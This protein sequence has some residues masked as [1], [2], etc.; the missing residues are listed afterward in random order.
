MP[1]D[2]AAFRQ[3][4]GH[5]A[6]GVTVVTTQTGRERNGLTVASFASLSLRPPL[7][8]V[9][10]EKS[11]KS[12]DAIVAAGKFAVNILA[13]DQTAI[14]NRFATK[15]EDKFVDLPIHEGELGL[16][17]IDGALANIECQLRDTLPGG[18]HSIFVGEVTAAEMR[19]GEP[20]LYFR[21]G[22]R[23]INPPSES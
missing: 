13:E 10:V 1:I 18:D 8:L 14:S 17:L 23:K 20:L 7:I 19:D 4:M 2:E 21:S 12:H 16:P 5:F 9:C 15:A 22:Y 11:V 6:C 3:A